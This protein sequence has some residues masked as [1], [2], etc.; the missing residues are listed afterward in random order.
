MFAEKLNGLLELLGANNTDIAVFAGVDRSAIS[1][2]KCGRRIPKPGGIAAARLAEAIFMFADDRNITDKLISAISCP[3][4]GHN[5]I[6]QYILLYLYDGYTDQAITKHDRKKAEKKEMIRSYGAR[7]DAAMNIA[8]L[9]NAR[10]AKT[11]HI[12]ASTVSRFRK[13]LRVPMAN[14]QLT[15]DINSALFER[16]CEL[17]RIPEL[18]R[19]AKLPAGLSDDKEECYER[20]CDWLCD[21]KTENTN[22]FVENLLDN[23]LS[24]SADIKTPLPD[25]DQAAP[26]IILQDKECIYY[27]TDGMRTAVIRFLGNAVKSGAREL[28]L[29]SDQNMDWMTH[30]LSFRLKWMTL[31][32]ECVKSGVRIRIIHNVDRNLDEMTDAINSWLPLYMSGIIESYYCKKQSFGKFSTTIFLCPGVA[33]ISSVH[34]CGCEEEGIYRYDT[35]E[36]ALRVH[37]KYYKKLLSVSYPLIRIYREPAEGNDTCPDSEPNY[38]FYAL[39]D[40]PFT[41]ISITVSEKS[42]M[43]TRLLPPKTTFVFSHPAM[44]EAFSV[45][46]DRLKGQYNQD[47]LTTRHLLERYI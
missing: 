33:C 12:D 11:L 40:T 15:D 16:I 38:R 17:D 36:K 14:R 13:G 3:S 41:N 46:A 35:D 7:L 8:G 29:Y 45:Y 30:E 34:V 20:F 47:K 5:D 23:I 2:I 28:W 39:P 19:L 4:G 1:R 10:L 22:S 18:L 37:E 21:F 43:V 32:R 44:C 31:M 6:I 9:S 42:V 27:G 25:F 26:D 24:F